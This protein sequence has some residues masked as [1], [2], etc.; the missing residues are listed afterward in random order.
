MEEVSPCLKVRRGWE[1]RKGTGC[2]ETGTT[3][4]VIVLQGQ[5]GAVAGE[6]AG[7]RDGE[8][9]MLPWEV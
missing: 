4:S 7:E 9:K 5:L 3:Q 6:A 1:P 8:G 2:W